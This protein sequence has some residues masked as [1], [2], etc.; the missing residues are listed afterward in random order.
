MALFVGRRINKEARAPSQRLRQEQIIQIEKLTEEPS[1][2]DRVGAGCKHQGTPASA[3]S[4]GRN[5]RIHNQYIYLYIYI[6]TKNKYITCINK[7]AQISDLSER[8]SL[9]RIADACVCVTL[10]VRARA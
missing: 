1:F 6:Y 7:R 3:M 8:R 5:K 4:V 2:S 10:L 9:H